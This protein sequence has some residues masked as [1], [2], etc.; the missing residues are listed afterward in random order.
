MANS[1]LLQLVNA[2]QGELGLAVSSSVI[3][4][5]ADDVVQMRYLINAAG[6]EIRRQFQWQAQIVEYRFYTNAYAYTG[7]TTINSTTLSALSST[8]GITTNPTY[9]QVSGVGIPEDTYLVSVNAG[10]ATAVM[11]NEATATGTSVSLTFSQTRYAM[12]SDY[13]RLVDRTEWD[14]SQHWEMLGPETTQ[15]KEWLKSGWISTGPRVRF[16]I[17]GDLFQ[18]WPA[19]ADNEL[20]G[21]DYVSKYWVYATTATTLTKAAFAL[22]TDT[23]SFPDRLL[24]VAL[25]RAYFKAKGFQAV[26][27]DE[28][29][30]ELNNAKAHDAGSPTLSL[31]PRIGSTLIGWSNIPD[32]GYGT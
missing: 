25:K 31:A 19:L 5:T 14:K 28:Y 16:Y 15:Q 8:T 9:F 27:D 11:S 21:F 32:A 24:V 18:I 4:N 22:D 3:G 30:M 29:R 7:N 20:L 10:A 12:P 23:A 13:D 17:Q 2:A 1:T 26:F 6:N